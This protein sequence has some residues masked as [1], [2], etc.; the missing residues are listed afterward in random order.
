MWPRWKDEVESWNKS[1]GITQ[2]VGNIAIHN[3]MWYFCL[4][5]DND[6]LKAKRHNIWIQKAF[7]ISKTMSKKWFPKHWLQIF[8]KFCISD[9][10]SYCS[11]SFDIRKAADRVVLVCC[12]YP[13][14]YQTTQLT[15]IVVAEQGQSTPDNSIDH[16]HTLSNIYCYRK[17]S[18]YLK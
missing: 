3:A 4:H 17:S 13:L 10:Q 11:E 7:R 18:T 16:C 1:W 6:V 12:Y 14:Q 5:R 15:P 2:W 9:I 8:E